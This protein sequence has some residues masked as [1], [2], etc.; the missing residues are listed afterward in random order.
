MAEKKK[1]V[2]VGEMIDAL[3]EKTGR[4]YE[5][6]KDE[7]QFRLV[8]LGGC[9]IPSTVITNWVPGPALRNYINTLLAERR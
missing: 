4:D 5:I 8:L 6:E 9:R 1:S 7:E 2:T 3:K